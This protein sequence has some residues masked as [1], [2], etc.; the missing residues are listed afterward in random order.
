MI[1]LAFA[2]IV[3]ALAVCGLAFGLFFGRDPIRT[4]CGHADRH[5]DDRC[6]DCPLRGAH[7]DEEVSV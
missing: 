7:A 6:A 5:D 2:L 4:S 1:E 3:L